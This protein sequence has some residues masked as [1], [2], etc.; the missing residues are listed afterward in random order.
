MIPL[1]DDIPSETFPLVNYLLIAINFLV[2]FYE[3]TLPPLALHRFL[4]TFGFVPIKF[5]LSLIHGYPIL[6]TILPVF[7]SMFLHGGW[8]HILG[9]MLFLYIF[10]DNVEDAMGHLRYLVFYIISGLV[11][12]LFQYII[13]PHAASPMI[14]ASG[15]I[16]GVLGAYFVLYPRAR[17]LTLVFFFVFVDVIYIPAFF[18]LF[19]WFF[20][21]ILNGSA[22]LAMA[23][24]GG[25]AWWAHIGGFVAGVGLVPLFRKKKFVHYKIFKP[26]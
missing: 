20:L 15:A 16:A 10:G 25:V 9:N 17:I 8:F 7:T 3:L 24:A 14:G 18:F 5:S 11:A 12:A 19:F 26:W 4:Y 21:Q 1:K 22:S 13:S 2:F 6:E 23:G